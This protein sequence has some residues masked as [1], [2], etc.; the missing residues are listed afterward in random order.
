MF[1]RPVFTVPYPGGSDPQELRRWCEQL[2]DYGLRL[3]AWA[4]G[5]QDQLNRFAEQSALTA[6]D[7]GTVNS[8]DSGTDDVIEANRT[9]I[10]EIEAALQ[11]A[12]LLA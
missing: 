4:K 3:D 2:Y 1:K 8:G 10:G 5:V 12:D 9:R 11:A 7:S 6:E